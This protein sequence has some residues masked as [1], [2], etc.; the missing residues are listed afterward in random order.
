[1]AAST[2]LDVNLHVHGDEL[3]GSAPL[4]AQVVSPAQVVTPA[5]VVPMAQV[6]STTQVAYCFWQ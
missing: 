3:V 6:D 5:P 1:M 2:T 4:P